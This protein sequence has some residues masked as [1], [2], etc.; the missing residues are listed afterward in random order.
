M[1]G[2]RR[3]PWEGRSPAPEDSD[4]AGRGGALRA[5]QKG[6][7]R[8]RLPL[9]L[10]WAT[11]AL[12]TLALL[13]WIAARL[14]SAPVGISHLNGLPCSC[15]AGGLP[16]ARTEYA[17]SMLVVLAA[18][19]ENTSWALNSGVKIPIKVYTNSNDSSV[20]IA[21]GVLSGR[22]KEARSY[23]AAILEHWDHLPDA[24]AFMHAHRDSWHNFLGD[25]H[26]NSEW[27]LKN[28]RW[29]VNQN[30]V[31]LTC[32]EPIHDIGILRTDLASPSLGTDIAYAWKEHFNRYLG[33]YPPKTIV[34]PCCAQF[35]VTRKAIQKHPREFYEG[36]IRWMDSTLTEKP[37]LVMEYLWQIMFSR[38]HRGMYA[39]SYLP[40]TCACYL[41][42]LG[43]DA[44]ETLF[45]LNPTEQPVLPW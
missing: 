44:P 23:I 8:W 34:T 16:C 33:L 22:G 35:L 10:A 28:L 14:T 40:T 26:T 39:W 30:Y 4:I 15:T 45:H 6:Q 1:D 5:G 17:K 43:C 25:T 41:Y 3:R 9:P 12:G 27:R 18:H 21:A 42:G 29:P 19:G 32:K 2:I 7:R 31:D 36:M 11:G 24:V 20:P 38:R 37:E 13:L